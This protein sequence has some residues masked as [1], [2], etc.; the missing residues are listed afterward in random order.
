MTTKSNILNIGADEESDIL[1]KDLILANPKESLDTKFENR[2]Q[3]L[4]LH[5][6][7][8]LKPGPDDKSVERFSVNESK[9]NGQNYYEFGPENK[10]NGW[11]T[12]GPSFDPK[13]V[14]GRVKERISKEHWI[15]NN[16]AKYSKDSRDFICQTVGNAI[17]EEQIEIY[18]YLC[19]LS[20]SSNRK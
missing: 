9:K 7:K 6:A 4:L 12:N 20:E 11:I 10:I 5:G 14:L 19:Y 1:Y 8:P 2:L 16:V 13:G 15:N 17:H 18:Q 3:K